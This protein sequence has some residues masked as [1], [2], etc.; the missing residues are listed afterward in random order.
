MGVRYRILQLRAA[1]VSPQGKRSRIGVRHNEAG[2]P[3]LLFFFNHLLF[4]WTLLLWTRLCPP[5]IYVEVLTPNIAV[6]GDM[7]HL[8]LIT[9]LNILRVGT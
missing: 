2:L 1:L 9:S 6:F 7:T 3:N 4:S 5:K 8:T